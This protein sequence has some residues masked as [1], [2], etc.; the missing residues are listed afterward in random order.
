[1]RVQIVSF[2]CVLKNKLGHLIS[3]SFNQDVVT[4]PPENLDEKPSQIQALAGFIE[5]LQGIKTGEKK[6]IE[7]DAKEAYGFYNSKLLIEIPRSKLEKGKYLKVG[8]SVRA[9]ITDD[10]QL[11]S[12]RVVSAD[13]RSVTLDGNHPLAGQDLVFDV[14]V[15]SARE[16]NEPE[17]DLVGQNKTGLL[18]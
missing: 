6:R 14:E 8:D 16:E 2:H 9:N 15:T 10:C 11:R 1:M 5:G 18:C 7:V 4:S 12:Y 13:R 17:F 3:S